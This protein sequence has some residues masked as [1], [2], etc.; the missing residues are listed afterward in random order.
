MIYLIGGAPRCGKTIL[1]KQIAKQKG[2]S[3]LSTDKIR[4][5]VV[6]C[7]PRTQQEEK[8]PYI[9]LQKAVRPYHDLNDNPPRI[10]L[11]AEIKESR[12]IWPSTR[13]LI[14]DLVESDEDF[15]IEGVHLMPTLIHQ[16]KATP[17]WKQIRLLY[18][19]KT[20]MNDILTGFHKNTSK[21]DWLTGALSNKE[22]LNKVARMVQTK[23]VYIAQQAKKFG[24]TVID[25]GKDFEKKLESALKRF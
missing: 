5:M 8:F 18:L 16:L 23:S 1:S 10:L 14:E 13:K 19:V 21:H 22:L 7:T 11:N 25:T 9:K 4:Q 24:F 17:V 15:V 3:W 6:A 20:D 2:M 12:S